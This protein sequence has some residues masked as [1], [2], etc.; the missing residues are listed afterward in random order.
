MS[1]WCTCATV[2]SRTICGNSVTGEI[3]EGT[4]QAE[5]RVGKGSEGG[6][7]GGTQILRGGRKF[8]RR[9]LTCSFDSSDSINAF[10]V[11]G[12]C[13]HAAVSDSPYPQP[14]PV[15]FSEES[16]P[17]DSE[18]PQFPPNRVCGKGM[19]SHSQ[20]RQYNF[21]FSL[22]RESDSWFTLDDMKVFICG[23][24]WGKHVWE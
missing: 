9:N 5:R 15:Y 11:R 17:I 2:S 6:G 20:G 24:L 14:S 22:C 7:R 3:P 19:L 4:E 12:T 13:M 16:S 21:I 1:Q 18:R 23:L 10:F 8:P